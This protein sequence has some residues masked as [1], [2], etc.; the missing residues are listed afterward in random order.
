MFSIKEGLI[1]ALKLKPPLS[2]FIAKNN[3]KSIPLRAETLNARLRNRIFD[4]DS[5]IISEDLEFFSEG[6]IRKLLQ[7]KVKTNTSR[8]L[9]P[10][11]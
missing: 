8:G 4:I 2:I 1:K 5:E 9:K 10:T 3:L 11:V 6:R 7:P